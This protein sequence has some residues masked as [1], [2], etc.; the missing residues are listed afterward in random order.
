MIWFKQVDIYDVLI[1]LGGASFFYG[2]WQIYEPAA[3]I[4]GGLALITVGLKG[5]GS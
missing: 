1:V 5:G 4:T 3:W 2:A